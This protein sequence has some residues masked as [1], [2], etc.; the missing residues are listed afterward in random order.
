[1]Q[2]EVEIL[3]QADEV[4]AILTDCVDSDRRP[5][6]R[7]AFAPARIVRGGVR[8]VQQEEFRGVLVV[9]LGPGSMH[10]TVLGSSA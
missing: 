6:R 9:L 3:A 7:R 1:M 5:L 2:T 10:P 8:L 4:W